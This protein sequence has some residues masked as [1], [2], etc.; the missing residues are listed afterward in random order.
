LLIPFTLSRLCDSELH[1]DV[2]DTSRVARVALKAIAR[3]SEVGART[4]V[5]GASA[6]PETHGQYV[7]DCKITK[8]VGL[9]KGQAGADLQNRV[10][11]ELCEKLEGIQPGTT[12]FGN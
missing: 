5:H 8:T 10:W 6:G 7:P 12:S 3:T 2:T 4:L 1:R 9:C 11:V